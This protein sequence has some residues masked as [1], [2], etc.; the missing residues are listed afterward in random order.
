MISNN[1][2]NQWKSIYLVRSTTYLLNNLGQ[3]VKFCNQSKTLSI[4]IVTPE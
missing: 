1:C 2:V 4:S 3:K